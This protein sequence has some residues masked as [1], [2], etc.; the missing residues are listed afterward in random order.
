MENVI[1]CKNLSHC[2]GKKEIYRDLNFT[3]KQGSIYGLLGKN[4]TG[5]TT[6]INILMGFLKPSGGQCL[7]FGEDSHNLPSHVRSRIGLLLEGHLQ[8]NFMTI[9]QIE[10]FYAPFY[11]KWNRDVYYNL[12]DKMP[13]SRNQKIKHMSCGQQSQ[14]ALGLLLA[15]D[16]DLLIMDDYSMGLDAGYRRLFLEILEDFVKDKAKTVFVTSHIVQDLEQLVDEVLF[17]NYGGWTYQDSLRNFMGSFKHYQCELN[18]NTVLPLSDDVIIN[19]E[20]RGN[21]ADVYAFKNSG[22]VQ[23]HLSEQNI[24]FSDF[25]EIPMNLEDAFLGLTGKY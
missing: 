25:H 10:K 7:I 12:M 6:T 2:Y 3:V 17:M 21:R 9:E 20:L 16:P 19:S 13:V 14:V 24:E 15:Q 1:E 22:A 4:G 8:Y 5:K 11:P 18:G 23:T